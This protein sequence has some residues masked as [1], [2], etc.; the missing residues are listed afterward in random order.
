METAWDPIL[1]CEVQ[2][3]KSSKHN[4]VNQ[5]DTKW[6]EDHNKGYIHGYDEWTE[7]VVCMC[8]DFAPVNIST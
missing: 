5:F 1:G 2:Q 4:Y 8:G 3:K 6:G 7:C